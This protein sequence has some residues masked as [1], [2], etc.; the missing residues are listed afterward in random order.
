MESKHK[1]HNKFVNYEKETEHTEYIYYDL[2]EKLLQYTSIK[3]IST[4]RM[5]E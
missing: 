1:L 5:A 2:V 4:F 3:I